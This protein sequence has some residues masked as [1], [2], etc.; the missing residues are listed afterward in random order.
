MAFSGSGGTVDVSPSTTLTY[1]GIAAG[2]GGMTKSGAG[3][4]DVTGATL[5]VGD[6]VISAGTIS[7]PTATVFA[8]AGNWTNNAGTGALV[9]GSGTVTLNGTG[10][11]VIG[12]AFATTFNSLTIAAAGG[13]SLAVDTTV[14][15][16]L[17]LSTFKVTTGSSALAIASGGAVTRTTGYVVGNLT[18]AFGLGATSQSFEVGDATT[19]AP[20][21][22]AFAN[23]SVAGNLTARTT[24]GEHPAI[25]T[26]PIDPTKSA[27][28][29]W[30]LTNAG[31]AY[32]TYDATFTFVSGDLDAG[33]DTSAF[34]V[35]QYK[36]AT[37]SLESTGVRTS[38]TTQGTGLNGFGDFAVGDFDRRHRLLRGHDSPHRH[39][40]ESVQFH[41]DGLRLRGQP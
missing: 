23:V 22:V 1:G 37:W 4:L 11:A 16:T 3:A 12:G 26:S 28:R 24:P 39:G 19:Y 35:G 2:A 40:G 6:L 41:G 14:G 29:Y 30:T 8:V 9:A 20:V 5:M 25:A 34:V 7:A 31:I 38:T 15:G 36:A 13:V 10:P 27:N 21:T 17:S 32:T 18:K 33:A